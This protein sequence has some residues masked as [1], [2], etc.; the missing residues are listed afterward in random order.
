M[1]TSATSR[2][3]S[4]PGSIPAGLRR[5]KPE[6]LVIIHPDTAAALGIAGDMVFIE[7]RRGRIRQ[8][9]TLDADI[10]PRVVSAGYGWWFP[11]R[12]ES[13]LFGSGRKP[14]NI[15]RRRTAVQPGDGL[16]EDARV[17][18]GRYTGLISGR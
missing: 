3:R 10:D 14:T 15:L 17:S 1:L 9:A 4:F 7:N 16:S 8:K 11:E 12:G 2:M 13:E 18:R 5:I 6:P